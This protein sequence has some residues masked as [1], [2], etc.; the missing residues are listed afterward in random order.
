MK[1]LIERLKNYKT[2]IVGVVTALIAILVA[3]GV[4]GAEQG[5]QVP[6]QF[7]LT[8]DSIVQL[9][10]AISGFILIFSKDADKAG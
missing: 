6:E 9:L 8:Y 4:L 2:T 5:S 1:D 7:T 3:F 10:A